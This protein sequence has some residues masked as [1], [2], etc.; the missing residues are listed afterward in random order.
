MQSPEHDRRFEENTQRLTA[1]SCYLCNKENLRIFGARDLGD[2]PKGVRER[3]KATITNGRPLIQE[4]LD[5]LRT[6]NR[7]EARSVLEQCLHAEG[8]NRSDPRYFSVLWM[9]GCIAREEGDLAR[10]VGLLVSALERFPDQ[11]RENHFVTA[12][13]TIRQHEPQNETRAAAIIQQGLQKLGISPGDGATQNGGKGAK[14][15]ALHA[16]LERRRTNEVRPSF[17]AS[18]L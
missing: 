16:S 14:L 10:A 5:A 8:A 4:A 1:V 6:G 9:L 11:A 2:L 17:P 15:L 12:A 3:V 13:K 18:Y 7:S